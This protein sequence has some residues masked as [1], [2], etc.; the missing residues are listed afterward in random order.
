MNDNDRYNR[1]RA[2]MITAHEMGYLIRPSRWIRYYVDEAP[3]CCPLGALLLTTPNGMPEVREHVD[4]IEC[5]ATVL[6][7]PPSWIAGFVQAVDLTEQYNSEG[8]ASF[9]SHQEGYHIGQLA[10]EFMRYSPELHSTV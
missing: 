6:D 9:L 1:I 3:S 5:A 10:R 8:E 2:A 7:V 4:Y